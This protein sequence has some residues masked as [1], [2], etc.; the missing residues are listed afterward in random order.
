MQLFDRIQ[1][2]LD[3]GYGS[4]EL[5]P[6]IKAGLNDRFDLRPYQIDAFRHFVTYFESQ[7]MRQRPAQVLFHMATGSGKTLIMAGLILY[8]YQKGYRNFLFFVN[9][10]NIIEKTRKNF[11][12]TAD[13]KYLFADTINIDG[14]TIPI[15]EVENFQHASKDCINI[16][17]TTI[18]S[19]YS[20][21]GNP[22]ENS[23]TFDD[24]TEQKTVLISDEAHHINV[25]TKSSKLTKEESDNITSWE[26][27]INRVFE[28]N[29]EN[30]LLEFTATCELTHP[31][32]K[33]KY[34]NK[35]IYDY[36]LRKYR[37]DRFSKEIYLF[38]IDGTTIDRALTALV[39]SQYRFKVFQHHGLSI[40][41]VI[42]FK[43]KGIKE[44]RLFYE[45]FHTALE[46]LTAEK[47]A[48]LERQ[49][50]N[51]FWDNAFQ[52]FREK[53]IDYPAFVRELQAEFGKE[54]CIIVDSKEESTERQLAVNSLERPDNPYRA[55]FAVDKLNEGWDVLNL[56]DIVRT[57]ETRDSQKGKPGRTTIQEAQL[58]GRGA[59]YCPF[60]LYESQAEDKYRRK[61][62]QDLGNPL[63]ACETLCFH[64]K[65]DSRY[66]E[67]LTKALKETG[68]IDD[69]MRE[70][71]YALKPDF[72]KEPYYE[73]GRVYAND[74]VEAIEQN[75]QRL[76]E[77]IQ[78][79]LL[80]ATVDSYQHRLELAFEQAHVINNTA[81]Q[82]TETRKIK[83]IAY[84]IVR[85]ALHRFLCF[86]FDKLKQKI[87]TLTSLRQF[88]T[89]PDYLGDKIIKIRTAEAT[90]TNRL[91]Y[92]A[93]VQAFHG[94]AE[95]IEKT[96]KQYIGTR[97]F[98]SF[99]VKK[100]FENK[101]VQV[102]QDVKVRLFEQEKWFVYDQF[103]GTSEE[104]AFLDYFA[105]AYDELR[106]NQIEAFLFRNERQLKIYDFET[107]RGFE[108][109]FILIL[110]K[111][112]EEM[113][114][115]I[116]I[117]PKG[118]HLQAYD[119][120]KQDFL[121]SINDHQKVVLLDKSNNRLIGLPMYN[122][123][124]ST[125]RKKFDE[126]FRKCMA[127]VLKVV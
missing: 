100:T 71:V 87:P 116:F 10:E 88:A 69:T 25:D 101:R 47:I 54:R 9:R 91:L 38:Q 60:V 56:F 72:I 68:L 108:P 1:T 109:D 55:V 110:R 79:V 21:L 37:E 114:Y 107:G 43:S 53:T 48:E 120:W 93:C 76:Q 28:K 119:E 59:R 29:V 92:R 80:E 66:I 83:S 31:R 30:V 117:E 124:D 58:I 27:C 16:H 34:E 77:R 75:K 111:D 106:K 8:L 99:S 26:A 19:L 14:E 36:P 18:Q 74:R 57:F 95:A 12:D 23:V 112:G 13:S 113:M 86:R 2:L 5:P 70:I 22:R 20:L 125:Q 35:I 103:V 50:R 105:D 73:N 104:N 52:Y 78:N 49:F 115:Q 81:K 42:L 17:F 15:R 40:K 67:E 85:K 118:E 44:S 33:E 97:E 4:Q 3:E 122:H 32:I 123:A 98:R 63:R 126:E 24:F 39:L 127:E 121:E 46:G 82:R 62:D 102:K 61:Y 84:P 51:E 96:E 90:L 6:Y 94:L 64:S 41:P 65:N 45:E 7:K 89:H 11:L